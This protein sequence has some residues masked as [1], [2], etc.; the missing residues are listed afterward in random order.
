MIC[1]LPYTEAKLNEL[2]KLLLDKNKLVDGL[3]YMQMTRG[4]E[5]RNH[6]YSRQ[7][8]PVLT[9]FTQP[10]LPSNEAQIKGISAWLTDDIRWLRCD[11]KTINLLGNVMVKREAADNECDEAI[12][13]RDGIITEGS[14]SNLFL[15]KDNVLY[16][17][18]ATNLILNGITRQLVIEV[19]R[20][21]QY[22]VVEES[23]PVDVLEHADEAFITSTTME[24]TP[25]VSIN[26]QVNTTYA[27]GPVTKDLQLKFRDLL[28]SHSK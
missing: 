17:H 22:K 14:S 20:D 7:S 16:T 3:I 12:M 6:L 13:Q 11:I 8:T 4:I 15:V 2:I 26:G 28:P 24:I 21:H 10:F 9:A 1:T 25:I 18:P 23:F 5:P 27:I 19:A